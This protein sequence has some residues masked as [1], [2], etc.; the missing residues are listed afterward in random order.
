[1]AVGCRDDAVFDRLAV[2]PFFLRPVAKRQI[3]RHEPLAFGVQPG[4]VP[5]LGQRVVRDRAGHD[6]GDRIVAHVGDRRRDVVRAHDLA[7]LLVDDLAL[8]VH[9]VVVFEELLPD[10]VVARLDLFLRLGQRLVDPGMD[11][12]LAFLEP[13][14]LQ[15]R[16]HAVRA[17][18]PHQ[19]VFQRHEEF[20]GAGVAL[21]AGAAAELVV[22]APAFVPLAADH[23]KPAALPHDFAR[24]LDVAADRRRPLV[25]AGHV[26]IALDVG[27]E[28]HFEVAAPLDVG[29][30]AG[31][32][33]R[34][35]DRP[36]PSGLRDDIGFLL[37]V[38]G[39]QD[40]VRDFVLFEQR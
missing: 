18:N 36:R 1:M 27:L 35:R 23:V 17:E 24:R 38:A 4:H 34:D 20:G 22:D 25:A 21:A 12:R 15:H 39:V 8:V 40:V 28:P 26:V 10:V 3:E 32:V 30:A 33:G 13:Q 7:A 29:G 31:H 5:L 14:A 19:V 6:I 16:I 37:V 2:D 9:H 11:D